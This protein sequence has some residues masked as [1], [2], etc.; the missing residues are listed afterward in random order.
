[1]AR[2]PFGARIG[3]SNADR[4]VGQGLVEQRSSI[5]N[6]S[7]G[8][9]RVAV[10]RRSSAFVSFALLDLANSERQN[11]RCSTHGQALSRLQQEYASLARP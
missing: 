9:L 7:V 8:K 2:L 10:S 11:E 4:E 1:M 5:P 3:V 6:P